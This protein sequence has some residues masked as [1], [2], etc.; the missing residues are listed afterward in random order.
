MKAAAIGLVLAMLPSFGRATHI[1]G[2]WVSC[3]PKAP[4]AY[5][6]LSVDPDGKGYRWTAEWGAPYAA[7]GNAHLKNGELIL[8]GCSLYRGEISTGCNEE[9]P[10][11]FE[12][13]RSQDLVRTRSYFTPT[14]LRHARWVRVAKGG[15]L[16]A[17]AR[18]CE[19]VVEKMSFNRSAHTVK[20]HQVAASRRVLRADDL[21]R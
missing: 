1:V 19:Q 15:S 16:Q 5:S 6:L 18:E 2:A 21:Q 10:P 13:L 3:N 8:R 9:R 14:D 17:L 11:V 20:Q 4:W 7:G 12:R